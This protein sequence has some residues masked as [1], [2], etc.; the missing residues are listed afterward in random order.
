MCVMGTRAELLGARKLF[1]IKKL[2]TIK[3]RICCAFAFNQ[4][5]LQNVI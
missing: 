1:A 2:N 4:M 5:D 3:G